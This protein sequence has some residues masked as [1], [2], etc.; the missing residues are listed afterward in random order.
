MIEEI[1]PHWLASLAVVAHTVFSSAVGRAVGIEDPATK[2]APRGTP[3]CQEALRAAAI[4]YTIDYRGLRSKFSGLEELESVF[5]KVL[6]RPAGL[7]AVR[8]SRRLKAQFMRLFRRRGLL[9]RDPLWGAFSQV[10]SWSRFASEGR[11]GRRWMW[12]SVFLDYQ[13]IRKVVERLG[14]ASDPQMAQQQGEES[15]QRV[16]RMPHE[17]TEQLVS[18]RMVQTMA[19]L[20]LRNYR[21]LVH[22]LGGYGEDVGKSS[23]TAV[24]MRGVRPVSGA[25]D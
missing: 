22:D 19:V 17:W 1:V 12:E 24:G 16:L 15:L 5:E 14:S 3:C 25:S 20:D 21:K 8:G 23:A 7:R 18:L 10:L 6:D 13:G 4:A 2:G 9:R 11:R